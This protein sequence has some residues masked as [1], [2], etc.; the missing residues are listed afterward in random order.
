MIFMISGLLII[1]DENFV[2]VKPGS[3]AFTGC[4]RGQFLG[5]GLG[6][7]NDTASL[8]NRCLGR[9]GRMALIEATLTI[10]PPP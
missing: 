8:W 1:N 10:T 7:S 9:G 2:S 5:K 6:Q 4:S 3:R